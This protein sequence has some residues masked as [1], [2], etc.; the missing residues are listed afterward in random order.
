[1]GTRLFEH[2]AGKEV[3]QPLKHVFALALVRWVDWLRSVVVG[4]VRTNHPAVNHVVPCVVLAPPGCVA[5]YPLDLLVQ[6]SG[7]GVEYHPK[8]LAHLLPHGEGAVYASV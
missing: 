4:L 1:M 2:S 7:C 3:P 6:V 8:D 5:L